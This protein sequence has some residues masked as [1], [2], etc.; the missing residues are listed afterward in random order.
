MSL[1]CVSQVTTR[2]QTRAEASCAKYDVRNTVLGDIGVKI[3]AIEPCADG[4]RRRVWNTI[5]LPIEVAG[6]AGAVSTASFTI[7]Q[8]TNLRGALQLYLQIHN[9]KYDT[10]A[11]VEVNN[12]GWSPI[13][14]GN[15]TLLGNATA[16]GG[17]GGGFHTLQM[18]MN[19]PAGIVTTGSN[20]VAFRFNQTDGRVSAFRVLAFNIEAADGSLLIPASTFAQDDPNTWQPPSSLA[21][22]ISTGQTLW[23]TAPI[24]VP[25]SSGPALINAHCMDC[26]T[27]DGRDLKYFNYSNN[28][29][30]ARSIFHGLTAAQGN[31]I[32]SYIRSLNLPNPGRPWNPPYQ[33]G[34]G[35]DSQPVD[36]WSAGAGLS[37]VLAS[38]QDL[39]NELFPG[40]AQANEFSP[41]GILNIRE[42]AI[43]LQF[44]D[45][46]SWLPT[47]HPM[48]AWPDFL[49]SDANLRYSQIRSILSPG[50]AA[51]YAAAKGDFMEWGGDYNTFMVPKELAAASTWTPA[52]VDQVYSVA[53]WV[54]VKNWELNQEFQLEGMAQTIF[55]N[56]KAEPRAWLSEFPFLSSPN[57]LHIPPA[58]PGLDNGS[59]QTWHYLSS[60]WYQVQL[61]LNSSEYQQTG[62]SPLDWGYVYA[63]LDALSY[64]D[65]PAQAGLLNLWMTKGLQISNNGIG[66]DQVGTGWSWYVADLSRQV[67]PS[68]RSVW[69]GTDSSTRT[70]ISNGIVQ[71]WLTEVQQFT[72]QQFYAGGVSATR[73][74]IPHQPD[75]TNFEDRVWYMI[76]QLRYFGVNQTLINQLANWAQSIWPLGNWAATTTAT[77]APSS[78]DPTV[79]F[80]STDQ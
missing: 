53:Q 48:D 43:P 50:S 80:C 64:T 12:S 32:A 31:Q 36:Q 66:P 28:S 63:M 42:T 2:A 67:S 20:T 78:G 30:R 41:A 46:N 79:I 29:I 25:T 16:Y 65:S 21:S 17:I 14:T 44:P 71:G 75:S 33:P 38:D 74:P 77:C 1:G 39:V 15:V 49:T 34:P 24:R 13:S 59:L 8:G 52:Y 3:G 5:T 60:I 62:N 10:E 4:F 26:H 51:S 54:L 72:P 35:L 37:A 9:L 56:P 22:D 45:W 58:S 6:P 55:T 69:A 73:H 27:Q 57:M 76:P 7:P 19:L 47:I 40:G 18:T 61:V 11:S 68:E 23:R 70:A